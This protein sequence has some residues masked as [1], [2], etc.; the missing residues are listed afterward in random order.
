MD[1]V[2]EQVRVLPPIRS[3][4]ICST[5]PGVKGAARRCAMTFG[6]P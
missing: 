4:R 6:H 1:G 2:Y 5:R 3:L